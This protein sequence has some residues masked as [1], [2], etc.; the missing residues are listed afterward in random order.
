MIN[1]QKI[2][3]GWKKNLNK[4]LNKSSTIKDSQLL[5]QSINTGK[6][7]ELQECL[8]DDLLPVSL[9]SSLISSIGSTDSVW[10]ACSMLSRVSETTNNLVV[11]ENDYPLGII[12]AKEILFNLLKN[13]TPYYFHDVLSQDIMNRKFY[14]DT[15]NARLDKV[16]EQMYKTKNE[17]IILQNSKHSFSTVSIREILEIGALCKTDYL[18][19][20]LEDLKIRIFRRDDTVEEI[21]KSLVHDN[22]EILALENESQLID[23]LTIIEKIAG[24]LNYLKD[25]N[26]FLELNASIF[27]LQ[28]PKLIP[29]KLSFSEICQTMLF[30]KHPYLITSNKLVTPRNILEILR[31]DLKI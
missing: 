2:T 9:S 7:L 4:I 16:F 24:D 22:A 18:A 23:P 19:S 29:D 12:G 15:R 26:N 5:F 28:H 17:F 1:N 3:N 20:D 14:L 27:K 21:I 31:K 11:I 25:C 6:K 8:F 13:P 10:I 30:M